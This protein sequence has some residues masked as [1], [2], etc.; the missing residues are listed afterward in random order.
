MKLECRTICLAVHVREGL[1]KQRKK[2]VEFGGV[3]CEYSKCFQ[4][5]KGKNIF[6]EYA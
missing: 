3:L 1:K 6:P 2:N 5:F 4:L